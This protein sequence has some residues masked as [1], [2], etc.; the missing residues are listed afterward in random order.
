MITTVLALLLFVAGPTSP[1]H[2]ATLPGD[3]ESLAAAQEQIDSPEKLETE[4][5]RGTQERFG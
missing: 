5:S 1:D 4:L 3:T 2:N